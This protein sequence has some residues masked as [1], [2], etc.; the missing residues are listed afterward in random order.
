MS[1]DPGLCQA[2]LYEMWCSPL[3]RRVRYALRVQVSRAGGGSGLKSDAVDWYEG[4]EAN[5]PSSA[6]LHQTL[7]RTSASFSHSGLM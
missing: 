5:E 4:V 2:L 1:T 6:R 7:L 3:N